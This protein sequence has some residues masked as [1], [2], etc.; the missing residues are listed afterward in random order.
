MNTLNT[1]IF[2]PVLKINHKTHGIICLNE[3]ILLR[4]D[5]NYTTFHLKNGKTI[6]IAH[7]LK[8]FEDQLNKFGFMRV[9][10]AFLVNPKHIL[11]YDSV[12]HKIEMDCNLVA[13]VSRRKIKEFNNYWDS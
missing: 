12:G 10:R 13:S 8:Y 5:I 2:L 11:K 9:H 1:Q 7:T 3:V 6:M 4:G